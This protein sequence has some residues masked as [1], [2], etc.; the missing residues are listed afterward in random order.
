MSEL[1]SVKEGAGPQ[2]EYFENGNKKIE[3]W[4]ESGELHRVGGPALI[5]Y[6]ENGQVKTEQW[7]R[8]GKLHHDHGPAVIEYQE[9]RSEYHME[10]KKYY[11]DG[12]LH[13]NDGPA[14]IA[15]TRIGLI[16]Y[17]VWYNR[18]VMGHF[19]PEP[20]RDYIPDK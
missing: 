5:E 13:R 8:H 12:L 14:D 1:G 16:R 6:F 10:R 2:A 11:K 15:Y 9:D 19:E 3:R 4:S 18:G 20:D 7:Y 17:A